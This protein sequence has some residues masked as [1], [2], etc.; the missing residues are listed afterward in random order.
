MVNLAKAIDALSRRG[1]DARGYF[2]DEHIGMGHRRLSIIDTA[3]VANQ[4]MY[5]ALERYVIVF[6]GEIFNYKVLKEELLAKGIQFRTESD[7]EVLLQYFI[8]EKE[9]CLNRFLGFFAFAV[10]DKVE[11][12]LFIAR[13]RMGVKPLLYYK[14]E[15]KFAFASEMKSLLAYNIPRELDEVSLFEYLQLNYVPKEHSIF[16]NIF[17]L[18]PGEYIYIK[19]KTV[20]QQNIFRFLFLN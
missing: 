3:S 10:F 17:R 11:K 15:D 9:K 14:D 2:L 1:P 16:K 5:D 18:L 8:L 4:P 20:D 7:T 13:D 6:N 19:E 12:S